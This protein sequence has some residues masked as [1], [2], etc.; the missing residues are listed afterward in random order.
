MTSVV[1][2]PTSKSATR[3]P[4]IHFQPNFLIFPTLNPTCSEADRG[5]LRAKWRSF[6]AFLSSQSCKDEGASIWR[7]SKENVSE[8]RELPRDIAKWKVPGSRHIQFGVMSPQSMVKVS[9]FEVTQRDL[10]MPDSRVPVKGGVLDLRLVRN[11]WIVQ[12]ITEAAWLTMLCQGYIDENCNLRDMRQIHARVCWSLGLFEA[13]A[14]YLPHWLFSSDYYYITADLQGNRI[15]SYTVWILT[16][17]IILFNAMQTCSRVMLE[18]PDRRSYLRRLRAPGLDNLTR[19]KIVKAIT[20]KCKKV[21]YCPHCNAV[22]GKYNS[23]YIFARKNVADVFTIGVVKK[24]GPMK[25]THDKYRLKRVA[26]E[27]EEF[28]KSFET[29]AASMPEIKPHIAKAQD[30]LNPL[31]VLRLFQRVT[32][33]VW[34]HQKDRREQFH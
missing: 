14:S 27:L 8:D 30:D 28:R 6:N 7:Y 15:K 17:H 16:T 18:E 13:C 25:I 4:S 3:T 11:E 24:I 5:D 19:Q 22:N 2:I 33:E 21:T 23:W 10:Y 1:S 31:R 9:E 32:P 12:V 26:N 29:A 34:V 20:D